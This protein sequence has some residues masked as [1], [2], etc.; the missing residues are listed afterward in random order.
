ASRDGH[1]FQ[2]RFL[3]AYIRPGLDSHNWTDR[4]NFVAWGIVPTGPREMS[5][6]VL[7]HFR[8]PDIRIRRGVLRTD[9]FV[10]AG[11]GFHGG[12]LTT[13]PLLF[14]GHAL[15]VNYSTAAAGS[16]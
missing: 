12:E 13:K 9:G 16:L 10:S 14:R 2:R 8:L 4:S 6:Y 11:A 1:C 5:I 3:E 7:E 15:V